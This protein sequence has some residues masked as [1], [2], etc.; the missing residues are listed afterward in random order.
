MLNLYIVGVY[1]K[2]IVAIVIIFLLFGLAYKLTLYNRYYVAEVKYN[3][4]KIFNETISAHYENN[5]NKEEV[6]DKLNNLV[7]QK[8]IEINNQAKENNGNISE[9][10]NSDVVIEYLK[11][12]FIIEETYD[13]VSKKIHIKK[14]S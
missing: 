12:S 5:Y 1:M 2:K 7:T 10:Y 11:Q 3:T 6:L 4:E 13:E 14:R 8:F 9:M